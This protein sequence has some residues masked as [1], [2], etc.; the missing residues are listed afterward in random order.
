MY[1]VTTLPTAGDTALRYAV[2]DDAS[3]ELR[4]ASPF[5]DETGQLLKELGKERYAEV[6]AACTNG[7]GLVFCPMW[8]F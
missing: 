7:A 3:G 4:P 8:T 5:G 6:V 2:G 1:Q